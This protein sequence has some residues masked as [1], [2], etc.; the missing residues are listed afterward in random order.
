MRTLIIS[1]K[2]G[3]QRYTAQ[4]GEEFALLERSVRLTVEAHNDERHPENWWVWGEEGTS[5]DPTL[6]KSEE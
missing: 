1:G 2:D 4:E 5:S 6:A 3:T